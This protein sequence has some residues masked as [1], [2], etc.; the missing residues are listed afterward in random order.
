[1]TG[2]WKIIHNDEYARKNHKMCFFCK[3]FY[4]TAYHHPRNRM[5][6]SGVLPQWEWLYRL[7]REI[8]ATD[9]CQKFEM[10]ELYKKNLYRYNVNAQ[11][12]K[13]R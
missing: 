12:N 4:C 2:K 9:T 7:M 13:G 1:M 5:V 6:C 8:S 11:S 3:R 10:H